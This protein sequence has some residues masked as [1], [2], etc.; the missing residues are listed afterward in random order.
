[1]DLLSNSSAFVFSS[2]SGDGEYPL[3]LQR[4]PGGVN[5]VLCGNSGQPEW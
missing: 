3:E 1:M 2:V 5:E 4:I